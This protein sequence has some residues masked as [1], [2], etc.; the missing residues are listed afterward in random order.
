M[1][2]C[3]IIIIRNINMMVEL[4]PSN[5]NLSPSKNGKHFRLHDSSNFSSY[6][7]LT[8]DGNMSNIK[9]KHWIPLISYI[10]Y[11][12]CSVLGSKDFSV[13]LVFVVIELWTNSKFRFQIIDEVFNGKWKSFMPKNGWTHT[14]IISQ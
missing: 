3:Q 6:F 12:L 5:Q 1:Y 10:M 14:I 2:T 8:V 11:I 9:T 13:I 7:I 4:V